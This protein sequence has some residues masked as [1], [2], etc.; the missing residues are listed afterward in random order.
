MTRHWRQHKDHCGDDFEGMAFPDAA[1]FVVAGR[2]ARESECECA[3]GMKGK[4]YSAWI[5]EGISIR[6]TVRQAGTTIN[7][8]QRAIAYAARTAVA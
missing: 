6:Q 4:E 8:V 7:A 2:A 3:H 1:A 5:A